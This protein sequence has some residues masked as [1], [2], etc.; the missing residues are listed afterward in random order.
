MYESLGLYFISISNATKFRVPKI[1][2]SFN[3][4]WTRV[5]PF[6]KEE[7]GAGDLRE[8][9]QETWYWKVIV[10]LGVKGRLREH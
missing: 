9:Y 5:L 4:S 2:Y 3:P 8:H 6:S 10:E 1:I 7:Q